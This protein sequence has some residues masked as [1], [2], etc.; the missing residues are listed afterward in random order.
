MHCKLMHVEGGRKSIWN[1]GRKDKGTDNHMSGIVFVTVSLF[2]ENCL[3]IKPCIP[4]TTKSFSF[5]DL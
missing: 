4:F 3:F 5:V 1:C 2:P